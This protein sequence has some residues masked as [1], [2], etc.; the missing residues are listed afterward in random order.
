MFAEIVDTLRAIHVATQMS[1][2]SSGNLSFYNPNLASYNPN[3]ASY[4][5][6]GNANAI[7]Y[8]AI[9]YPL[10]FSASPATGDSIAS[11]DSDSS[12]AEE[13]DEN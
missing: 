13:K 3:L 12:Q 2:A 5:V 6:L 8:R 4:G 11:I 7:G 10:V 1:V 9:T